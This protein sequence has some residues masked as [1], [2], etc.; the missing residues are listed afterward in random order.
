MAKVTVVE[1]VLEVPVPVIVM[2][3]EPTVAELVDV[4]VRVEVPSGVTGEEEKPLETPLGNPEVDNATASLYPFEP[5]RVMV[6]VVDCPCSIEREEG[7]A[8]MLKS[9]A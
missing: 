1:W 8:E 9:G 3:C 4:R 6:K 7:E 5:V 2:V